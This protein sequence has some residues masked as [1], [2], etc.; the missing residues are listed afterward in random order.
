MSLMI[1]NR[2]AVM[3][4]YMIPGFILYKK[5]IITDEGA[6]DIG[7]LLIYI[8]ASPRLYIFFKLCIIGLIILYKQ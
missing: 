5:R 6:K 3:L 2:I 8:I 4:A 1:L 7:K